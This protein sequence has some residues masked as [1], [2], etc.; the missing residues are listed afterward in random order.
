M[1]NTKVSNHQ[2]LQVLPYVWKKIIRSECE[3]GILEP[4]H[5]IICW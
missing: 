5:A 3:I 4:C 1:G 2:S